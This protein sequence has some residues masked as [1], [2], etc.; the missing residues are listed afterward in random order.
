MNKSTVCILVSVFSLN[1]SSFAQEGERKRPEGSRP[2]NPIMEAL[3]TDKDGSLQQGEIDM[4]VVALRKLDKN[5]DGT[6]S[7]D[8]LRPAG[9]PSMSGPGG[10]DRPGGGRGPSM[11]FLDK[12]KDG[13]ISKEEAPDRMKER[14]AQIDTN[15]DGY[16]DKAEMEKLIARFREMGGKGKGKGDK[17]KGDK[18]KGKGGKG[19]GGDED[20]GGGVKPKR[21]AV[22][23]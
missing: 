7:A 5:K 22:E 9:G 13:K 21:P 17:G 3:D 11:D 10:G 18:G 12:D 1:V 6:L 14:F 8:E 4:A 16:V 23:E 2:P 15:A 20:Q 19:A